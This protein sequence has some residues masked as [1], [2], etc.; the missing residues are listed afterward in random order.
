[1]TDGKIG[2]VWLGF[3]AFGDN[4]KKLRIFS[5]D[6]SVNSSPPKS[7]QNLLMIHL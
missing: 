7:A 6:S 5:D 4:V 2:L 1:M 3:T